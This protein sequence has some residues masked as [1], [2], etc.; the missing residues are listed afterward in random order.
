[1][2]LINCL[3]TIST[4]EAYVRIDDV[5]VDDLYSSTHSVNATVN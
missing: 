4:L 1:M 5:P 3:W 2:D